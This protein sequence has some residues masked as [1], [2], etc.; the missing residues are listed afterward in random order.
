MTDLFGPPLAT[1]VSQGQ[2]AVVAGCGFPSSEN[3]QGPRIYNLNPGNSLW[4]RMEGK[5]AL[6]EDVHALELRVTGML[7]D[8]A[9]LL[10]NADRATNQE[11]RKEAI[12]QAKQYAESIKNFRDDIQSLIMRIPRCD[13]PIHNKTLIGRYLTSLEENNES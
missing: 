4:D 5:D 11:Q 1:T 13:Y 8:A 10:E 3:D 12:L 7:R 2:M 6:L 9:T